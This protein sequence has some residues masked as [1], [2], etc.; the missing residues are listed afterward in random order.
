MTTLS[1]CMCSINSKWE[2]KN[3]VD[4]LF[5]HN[6]DVDFEVVVCH[7]T[8][9]NDGAD[10]LFESLHSK[11]PRFRTVKFTKDNCISWLEKVIAY[12]EQKRLFREDYIR[13]LK[14]NLDKYKNG[15][16]FDETQRFLWISSSVM[17]NKAI[18]ESKGDILLL[19][20]CD[21][22]YPFKLKNICDE[23]SGKRFFFAKPN[24]F[25]MNVVNSPLDYIK[26]GKKTNYFE[27]A[28]YRDILRCPE[29]AE[30]K[31]TYFVAPP[32]EIISL[33]DN[34]V[35]D[36]MQRYIHA[37]YPNKGQ[38]VEKFHGCHLTTRETLNQIGG[39]NEVWH[40]RAFGDDWISYYGK[41]REGYTDLPLW[42]TIGMISS[43]SFS[44][45][46][47]YKDLA[48]LGELLKKTDPWYGK[49]PSPHTTPV[50]LHDCP[51]DNES[52]CDYVRIVTRYIRS[53]LLAESP[54]VR[55]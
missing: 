31:D 18:Q 26:D 38:W 54:I 47:Y 35:I 1:V 25:W 30:L 28:L 53:I 17:Y 55:F 15:S 42:F 5:R 8:R 41:N 2:V 39:F 11:Y 23:V 19:T 4:F 45:F 34:L 9:V 24:L 14:T 37:C 12:Y 46:P 40:G 10:I 49:H 7:D 13:L 44:L 33:D 6:P 22:I 48:Q 29:F 3:L 27:Y 20:P 21:F 36:K 50:Y 43:Y 51:P 52:L 16:F 32:D